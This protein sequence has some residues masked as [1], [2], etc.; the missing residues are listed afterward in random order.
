MDKRD[1]DAL[2][3]AYSADF[4][5]HDEN[6]LMLGWCAERM[7]G[8]I[9][10]LGCRSLLSLG[11]GHRVVSQT[12]FGLLGDPLREYA[13]VEGS[14]DAV[15]DLLAQGPL[16]AG[17]Q[18][19]N[20]LFEEY[21]PAAPADAIEMGF[22][23]EHVD[24]PLPVVRRYAGFLRPGGRIFIAVPNARALHRLVGQRAG[25]LAD[26]YA[27]SEHDR[28]LGHQRYFDLASLR[29]LVEAAGLRVLRA[30]GV[31]L[32]CLT[33]AQLR[34]LDLPPRVLRAFC[35]VGVDYP[36]LGNAIYLEAGI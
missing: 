32:K 17:V 35:E 15:R 19:V 31:F 12:L 29:S 6:L 10:S 22:I 24:D 26:L 28:Q 9:R 2:T 14:A 27:L 33:T 30:E 3:G 4:K 25:L 20:A 1:L 36:E 34:S 7:S 11:I 5:F 23:L 18:V 8:T 21:A 13:I 16:P